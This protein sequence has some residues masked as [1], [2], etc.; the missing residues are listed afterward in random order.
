MSVGGH[1]YGVILNDRDEL[2]R[3]AP[4]FEEKPYSSPPNA[5]VV[6]MKPRSAIAKGVIPHKPEKLVCA[7]TLALLMARDA[8]RQTARNALNCV[9]AVAAALDVSLPQASYYRPAVAQKNADGFLAFG[10]WTAPSY[11][12]LIA[13][14]INGA[15]AHEWRLERLN[16][17]PAELLA[18]L[19]SFMTIKAGDVLL[20]GLPGD[21]PQAEAGDHLRIEAGGLPPLEIAIAEKAA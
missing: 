18:E 8:A 16:R 15:S 1:I 19:S 13:T 5:P 14:S 12:G 4:E 2:E 9:G 20:V 3:L 7:P 10:D 21:A 6:Y 11:P 17:S